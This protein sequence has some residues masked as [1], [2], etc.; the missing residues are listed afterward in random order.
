MTE[1]R[2]LSMEELF[3]Q[4]ASQQMVAEANAFKTVAKGVY[5]LRATKYETT[6]AAEQ[7]IPK[8]DG[9]KRGRITTWF[10]VDILSPEGKRLAKG[11]FKASHDE[12]RT[13]KGYQDGQSKMYG[14]LVKALGLERSPEEEQVNVPEVIQTFMVTPVDG[15]VALTFKGPKDPLTGWPTWNDPADEAEELEF[16]K[17]GYTPQNII[18]SIQVAK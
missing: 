3:D 18:R 10:S 7:T 5:R 1:A 14:Q 9:T 13:A 11:S 15:Y 4:R 2:K 16:R 12:V 17:R 6:E 8:Q